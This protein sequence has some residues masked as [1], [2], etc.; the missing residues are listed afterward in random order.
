LKNKNVRVKFGE[1]LP[2]IMAVRHVPSDDFDQ[3]SARKVTAKA[4]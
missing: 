1:V 2:C 3:L 4:F